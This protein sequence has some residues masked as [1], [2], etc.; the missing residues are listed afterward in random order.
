MINRA[1]QKI[2]PREVEE[3]IGR[4]AG[5]KA[6]AV[7]GLP[8]ELYG[9]RVVAYVVPE[10]STRRQDAS[11]KEQ[12]RTLCVATVSAYKCPAE[13]HLVEEIPLG[14]TGKIQRHRLKEEIMAIGC[15]N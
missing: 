4:H 5:V 3:V 10:E 12:L 15:A 6:C 9:E 13:F 2:S 8:D 14:P 7:I 1:G 11:F